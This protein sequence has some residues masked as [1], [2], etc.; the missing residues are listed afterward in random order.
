MDRN[1]GGFSLPHPNTSFRFGVFELDGRTGEVRKNGT[2]GP[3]LVGQPLELLLHL[4]ERPG[5][6]VTREELRQRLWPAD[7]FVDYDHSLNAAVNKLRE[8][9]NDTADNPRFIQTIPRRGYRFIAPVE[10]DETGPAVTLL[11]NRSTLA[12]AEAAQRV[13]EAEETS[14]LLSDPRDLP[15]IPP[16]YSRLLFAVLQTMYLSFYVLAMANL[17]GVDAALGRLLP[18]PLWAFVLVIVTACAGIP[19]RLYL[20]AAAA[21]RVRGLAGRFQKLFPVLFP[22]DELWSLSPFLLVDRIGWGLA[23]AATASLVFLPFSQRSVLLM[24]DGAAPGP[25]RHL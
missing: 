6:L 7:T 13:Q 8:A 10:L 14:Y 9:L 17:G 12:A 16:G 1:W 24:G 21:F 15:A 18:H 23:L 2:A 3:R 11:A 4:L 5:E 19:M 20:L 25:P 22:L